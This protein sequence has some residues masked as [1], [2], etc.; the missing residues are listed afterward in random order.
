MILKTKLILKTDY[1]L[2]CFSVNGLLF[3]PGSFHFFK[4]IKFIGGLKTSKK[5]S[6]A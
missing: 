5:N 2:F 4:G 3:I 1:S 6:P